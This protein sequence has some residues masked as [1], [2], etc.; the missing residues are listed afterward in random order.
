MDSLNFEVLDDRVREYARTETE[1]FYRLTEA[2]FEKIRAEM[3][4]IVYQ[5]KVKMAEICEWGGVFV[6]VDEGKTR[7]IVN[8]KEVYSTEK[9]I[10]WIRVHKTEE[11]VAFFET[12]GSDYGTLKIMENGKISH[13]ESGWY[14]DYIFGST[15]YTVKEIR[16]ESVA[17]ETSGVPAVFRGEEKVFWNQIKQGMGVDIKVYEDEAFLVVGNEQDSTLFHGKADDPETWVI[18]E[19]FDELIKVIGLREGEPILY[20]E[21]GFGIVSMGHSEIH[22]DTPVEDVA[23]VKEGLLVMEMHDAKVV[24]FLYD[25]SGKRVK[26]FEL[27]TPNGLIY[28]SSDNNRAACVF[29][30]FSCTYTVYL[31]DQEEMKLQEFNKVLDTSVEEHEVEYNGIN[32]HYFQLNAP[33]KSTNTIVYGYGG[34][35]ISIT[36]SFFNLFAYLLQ[37]GVNV[38]VCN[39]PGGSEYGENWHKLG[40]REKK[41][42]VYGSFQTIIKKLHSEGHKV[43]CYGVSNG[44]LLSSYTLTKIPEI[45]TGAVIGNPV[46]DLLKFHKLLAGMYWVSEYGDPDNP[47]DAK[48]MKEFSAMHTIKDAHYPPSLVYTRINDDRVHPYHALE[49]HKRVQDTGSS[50]YIMVG[51]GGHLG[52]TVKE[53]T[54]ETARIASFIL[55]CFE[56]KT[57]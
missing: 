16:N 17:D 7:I 54:D 57:S 45:L 21:R 14:H 47:E 23:M 18:K 56:G 30:S 32:V 42:N 53:M 20:I 5:K 4:K 22:F 28:M 38:V 39:L 37:N 41:G 50:T 46:I 10:T 36:P 25:W 6:T 29:T 40:M 48:F 43:I 27:G 51:E 19:H 24:P 15:E 44:G 11:K 12:S 8:W 33:K 55:L 31:Y 35:N 34:F 26:S 1:E 49:F 13:T 2:E 3:E 52:A 9:L